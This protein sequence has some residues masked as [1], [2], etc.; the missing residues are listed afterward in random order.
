MYLLT[1]CNGAIL[2]KFLIALVNFA[3]SAAYDGTLNLKNTNMFNKI[4]YSN[5]KIKKR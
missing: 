2:V 3:T 5:E 4:A 1:Q